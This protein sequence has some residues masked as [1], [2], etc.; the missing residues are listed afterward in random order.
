MTSLHGRNPVEAFS[1]AIGG[2]VMGYRKVSYLEQI[3]YILRYKLREFF[4]K[5]DHRAN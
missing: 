5:E 2:F 1:Y 4:R 3:W